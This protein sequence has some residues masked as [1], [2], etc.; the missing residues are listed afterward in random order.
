MKTEHDAPHTAIQNGSTFNTGTAPSL[1]VPVTP[2]NRE[3]LRRL[4]AAE[5]SAWQ[6]ADVQPHQPVHIRL[7][8][9][10]CPPLFRLNVNIR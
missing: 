4:R 5:L 7:R 1:R 10:T 3:I 9:F 2:A 6:D 8:R